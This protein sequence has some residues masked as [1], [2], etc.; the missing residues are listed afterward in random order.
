MAAIGAFDT[1]AAGFLRRFSYWV[2]LLLVAGAVHKF[3]ESGVG[4]LV[5]S[6]SSAVWVKIV[7]LAVS[8][9]FLLTPL[10]WLLSHLVFLA[11]LTSDRLI[12]LVP[13]VLIVSLALSGILGISLPFKKSALP[14]PMDS[15]DS[16]IPD[17]IAQALPA[18]LRQ[19]ELF[20]VEAEDH[21]VRIHTSNGAA[22]IRMRFRDCLDALNHDQ[23]F[24]V[25]RSWWVRD[26]AILSYRW[27]RG[28][29]LIRLANDLQVPV[30]RSLAKNLVESG[31]L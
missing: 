20:A 13:G 16:G 15:V 4:K 23:G 18:N 24:K 5:G 29:G 12:E 9:T 19:A 8:M 30:S 11:A 1:D 7:L 27:K 10:V 28:K 22:L 25:H 3:V 14:T 31:R 6:N 17:V 21:Y 26:V 2:P